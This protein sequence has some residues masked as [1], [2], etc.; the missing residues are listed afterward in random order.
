MI[1][2]LKT[3]L[4]QR[5]QIKLEAALENDE[6]C[7]VKF[8]DGWLLGVNLHQLDFQLVEVSGLWS[9]AKWQS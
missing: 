4:T 9:V 1:A 5:Q 3:R 7:F 2:T 8:T 6:A